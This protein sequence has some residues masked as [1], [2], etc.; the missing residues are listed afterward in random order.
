MYPIVKPYFKLWTI[1]KL[2]NIFKYKEEKIT[3]FEKRFADKIGRKYAV[4]FSSGR[5]A[6]QKFLEIQHIQNQEIVMPAY[7]CIVVPY[8]V[9]LSS[10]KPIFVETNQEHFVP[11]FGELRNKHHQYMILTHMFG[12]VTPVMEE[13]D[14]YFIIEDSCLALGSKFQDQK[15]GTIGDVSFFSF[16]QSKQISMYG[17]GILL[18][19]DIVIY[20]KLQKLKSNKICLKS[21]FK[22]IIKVFIYFM[23]F[24]KSIYTVAK[25]VSTLLRIQSKNFSIEKCA[26]DKSMVTDFLVSQSILGLQQLHDFE[27]ILS[28]RKKIAN[29]YY[30]YL[31]G[32]ECFKRPLT[33]TD[34]YEFSHYWIILNGY[35]SEIMNELRDKYGINT[36]FANEYSCPTTP[37]YA[38]TTDEYPYS[39]FIGSNI[40]NLPFYI[41]LKEKDIRYIAKSLKEV[42]EKHQ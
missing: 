15:A 29:Y 37:Y 28:E 11:S 5:I 32:L 16:N 39:T 18:T 26:L 12:E 7:T 31:E 35:R 1:I 9:E 17:G 14:K 41:G 19:D 6:L 23:Y 33:S 30:H 13:R 4:T 40:I 27:Y 8:A 3:E 24:Q 36:G 2:L 21:E 10:N 38:F 34:G 42:C 25:K 20:D 22:H